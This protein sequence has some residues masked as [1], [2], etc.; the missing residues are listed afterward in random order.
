VIERFIES[1][2]LFDFLAKEH[3]YLAREVNLPRYHVTKM[4]RRMGVPHK[5]LADRLHGRTSAASATITSLLAVELDAEIKLVIGEER[6]EYTDESLR[7]GFSKINEMR[8][9]LVKG[10]KKE[11]TIE[12]IAEQME[13]SKSHL[14]QLKDRLKYVTLDIVVMLGKIIEVEVFAELTHD[15]Q[16]TRE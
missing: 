14:W 9:E 6:T 13:M 10:G 4:A 11:F 15:F 2:K 7:L 1:Q 8:S 12:R 5:G 3:H 16:S